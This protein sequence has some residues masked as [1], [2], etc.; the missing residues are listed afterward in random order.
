MLGPMFF[1]CCALASENGEII[2]SKSK[3]RL[4]R[5][6]GTKKSNKINKKTFEKA[7]QEQEKELI[8]F[9]NNNRGIKKL[10]GARTVAKTCLGQY[11]TRKCKNKI[12]VCKR[13]RR[14]KYKKPKKR[15][16]S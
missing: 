1:C 12:Q 3:V 16:N 15:S 13:K 10:S 4:P 6:Y 14:L 8:E 11:Y 7:L 5:L 9:L 2:P